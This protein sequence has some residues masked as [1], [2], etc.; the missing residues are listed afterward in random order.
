[1]M[2]VDRDEERLRFEMGSELHAVDKVIDET[3]AFV[4][5][6]GV[7]D[8]GGLVLVMRELL[9]NAI[10]HGNGKDASKQVTGAVEVVAPRR[11][12]ITV[13][14]QGKGFDHQE[15]VLRMSD[16]PTQL[17]SRGLP[18]VN[19]YSDELVF[20]EAGNEVSVY[21]TVPEETAFA[22]GERDGVR[23]ISP[24]GDITA[25]VAERFRSL[26]VELLD[27]GDRR[28]RFDLSRV[29][30]IDSITLSIFVIF[31]NML[32]KIG[33][34]HLLEVSGANGDIEDVFNL[35]RLTNKYRFVQ[36]G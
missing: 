1:M 24:S 6:R 5:D 34:D 22:T 31:S 35:T 4:R 9:N 21:V 23:V 16:D 3:K 28:F 19:A 20:N 15:L 25:S 36:E 2:Q 27:A 32:E 26:L 29:Q 14:D 8:A 7:E 30:D 13:T 33:D 12:K 18:L 11:F 10:E 17:R